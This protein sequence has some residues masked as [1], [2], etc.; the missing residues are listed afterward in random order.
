MHNSNK[1]VRESNA[2][3]VTV[4]PRFLAAYYFTLVA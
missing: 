3:G 1:Y 4:T 2:T